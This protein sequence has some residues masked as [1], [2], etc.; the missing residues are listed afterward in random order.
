MLLAD[1][2]RIKQSQTRQGHHQ[3]KARANDHET[4]IGGINRFSG[5]SLTGD[6]AQKDGSRHKA[7]GYIRHGI[8]DFFD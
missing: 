3:N 1:H 7:L 6:K 8:F 2:A 4:G 5:K